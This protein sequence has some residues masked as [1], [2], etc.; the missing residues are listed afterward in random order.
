MTTKYCPKCPPEGGYDRRLPTPAIPPKL[1][2]MEGY[3]TQP[4]FY[5][6]RTDGGVHPWTESNL[7]VVYRCPKC[8]YTEMYIGEPT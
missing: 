6:R 1:V 7:P 3:P 4:M 5:L 2:E 8:G